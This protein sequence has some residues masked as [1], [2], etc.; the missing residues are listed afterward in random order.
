MDASGNV[1]GLNKSLAGIS[2]LRVADYQRDYSWEVEDIQALW[3]DV[4]LL[5]EGEKGEDHFLGTL[6]F[7]R[8]DEKAQA[9]ELVDGQQRLTTVF[10]FMVALLDQAKMHDSG[11]LKI[12]GRTFNV[13]QG[14]ES[15]L[16]GEPDF[17]GSAT[18]SK[19]RLVPLPFL[20][21]TFEAITDT[22]LTRAERLE[23]VPRVAKKGD[24]TADITLPLRRAYNFVDKTIHAYFS[25][26]KAG[27]DTHLEGVERLRQAFMEQLKVLTIHTDDIEDSLDVFMTLN[28]RGT[29]LGVFDLFRG[30]TL[31]AQI[32]SAEPHYRDLIFQESLDNWKE[33]LQ[34]LR[35][36]S[37]DKYLRHFA[38]TL[39]K[40]PD[41]KNPKP[42]TMKKLPKWT[43]DYIADSKSPSVAA[44]K[45]WTQVTSVSEDYGYFLKPTDGRVTD[46]YLEAM[47]LVGE[48]YR[49]LLIGIEARDGGLWSE[50]NRER[51]YSLLYRLLI[52]WP[53][54]G[55]NAQEL[56]GKFQLWAQDFKSKKD[57]LELIKKLQET[58]ISN[59]DLR[60]RLEDTVPIDESMAKSL[61][62][63]YEGR[64]APLSTKIDLQEVQLE[65]VAPQTRTSQWESVIGSDYS[66]QVSR[67]GNL[68]ILD[69]KINAKVKQAPFHE[70]VEEYK[71]SRLKTSESVTK[72]SISEWNISIIDS[73]QKWLAQEL[74]NLVD[75]EGGEPRPWN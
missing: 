41:T 33:I 4:E 43:S 67:L 27:S 6:I 12:G 50:K 45:L 47:R 66:N 68:M 7:Q 20:Q 74:A 46:Y 8:I 26:I 9:Y 61:L 60:A 52:R 69:R 39:S 36:Y 14:I 5:L 72:A 71:K 65:H 25:E 15:F 18:S 70:K 63:L 21:R 31:K 40:D 30:E 73:R 35:T 56:E 59:F 58:P 37:A 32:D 22:E 38:L 13:A 23:A 62:L 34:N 51:L 49:V 3:S 17:M 2:S 1:Q 10:L 24:P 28:N 53:L 57:P 11:S 54:S 64:V 75:G 55:G 29:P 42:L 44:K 16:L 48:S 19:S